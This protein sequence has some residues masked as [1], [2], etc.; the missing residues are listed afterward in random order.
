MGFLRQEYWSRLPFP[1]PRD[2]SD[3]G[4]K[5]V[6]LLSPALQAD[7]FSNE[8]PGKPTF[9]IWTQICTYQAK[10]YIL[11]ITFHTFLYFR[12]FLRKD[13][14]FSEQFKTHSKIEREVQGLSP[15]PIREYLP[16]LSTSS[17]T[18]AHLLQLINPY[19]NLIITQSL[20]FT[21]G[22]THNVVHS[23]SLDK[24]IMQV[25]ITIIVLD[26]VVSLY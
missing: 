20:Q 8:S 21:L 12:F 24:C 23:M 13:L 26:R 14:S 19:W 7:S 25:S 9:H 15:D 10:Y 5:P 1:S 16:A 2:L 3:P 4:I 6:S 18:V 22:F 17:T 11:P